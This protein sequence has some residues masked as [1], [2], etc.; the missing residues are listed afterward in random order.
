MIKKLKYENIDF[1]KYTQCLENSQQ[2]NWYAKKEVLD[3]LSG[4]WEILVYRDYEAVL[5]IPLIKKFGIKFVITPLF[6][7]Q[8]GVFSSSDNSEINDQFLKALKKNYKIFYYSFNQHNSF[9][10]S[11]EKR[12]NYIIPISD[13]E[14]LRR[15]KYF[16]GRKSTVKC[17][18]HLIYKE[19]ELNTKHISFI[20]NNFKGLTKENDIKKFKDY[21]N[22]LDRNNSLKLFAAYLDQQLINIAILVSEKTE[23]SLLA[24]INDEAYKKEDGASFLIDKILSH[25]IHK[26]SFN[27]MG[28]NIPGIERFFKS[29]G[30][31]LHDYNFIQNKIL[32][33]IYKI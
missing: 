29:F 11:A 25:Y 27:F 23:F 31:E 32:K 15:K 33:K 5:P 8:L 12:K 24:L 1:D 22:F 18:Q 6:C 28:S 2:K 26:K 16:K 7:Q 4:N 20:E 19:I 17:A 21:L 30:A 3:E 10:S 13:Y 14:I 9:S